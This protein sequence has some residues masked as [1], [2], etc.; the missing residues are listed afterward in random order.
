MDSTRKEQLINEVLSEYIPHT[1]NGERLLFGNP[2]PIQKLTAD[3]IYNDWY[4]EGLKSG[5][6]DE[7]E[8]YDLF[9]SKGI[10]TDELE[11]SLK[12]IE[13]DIEKL[14]IGMLSCIFK[15]YE[16]SKIKQSLHLAKNKQ[17]NLL[18]RKHSYSDITAEYLGGIS[19]QL[20]LSLCEIYQ[21]N[22]KY[23]IE[24]D[25]ILDTNGLFVNQIL[26]MRMSDRWTESVAR[27]LARSEPWGTYWSVYKGQKF[28]FKNDSL[29]D[30]Q[31]LIIT[32]S[33]VYDN[34]RESLDCPSDKAV[35]DDDALDG[36]FLLQKRK[37]D[38][39]RNEK[40][41]ED[42]ISNP[43]IGGADEIFLVAQTKDDI[44]NVYGLNDPVSRGKAKSNLTTAQALG[45]V[46]EADLPQTKMKLRMQQQQDYVN[47]V[48]GN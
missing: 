10:W 7:E 22:G 47:K 17:L 13:K 1:I 12:V 3:E 26:N 33:K 28:P 42:M 38:K 9:C 44:E 35:K 34:V 36:W 6:L 4:K 15:S 23:F 40:E 24:P 45:R 14:K 37:R 39:H 29:N 11:N 30:N 31:K 20:Y 41:A 32:W 5:L 2:T 27:E 18:I 21:Q 16:L 25:R 19:K 43:K 48:K 8:A 46:K